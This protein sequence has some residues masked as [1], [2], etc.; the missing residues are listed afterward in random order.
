MLITCEPGVYLPKEGI[1]IRIEDNLLI[2]ARGCE[3]TTRAIPRS[4]AGIEALMAA[5]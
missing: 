3:V 4:I 5:G 1:G 2:T